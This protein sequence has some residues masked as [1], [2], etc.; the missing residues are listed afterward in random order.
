MLRYA[1][2]EQHPAL[3]VEMR[4][5]KSLVVIRRIAIDRGRRILVVAPNSALDSWEDELA[6]ERQTYVR[7]TGDRSQRLA[8]LRSPFRWYL[9]NREAWRTLPEIAGRDLCA[10]CGGQG[11]RRSTLG[12]DV[13]DKRYAPYDV[14]ITRSGKWG[15]PFRIGVDGDRATVIQ[16][17]R[18]Y[19]LTKPNLLE[20]LHE[21]ANKRL[22]CVCA[23]RPCHGDV[24]R[25]L[26]RRN[27]KSSWCRSCDGR[28]YGPVVRKS[29]WEHVVVDESFLRNPQA[30]ITQFYL[31]SFRDVQHRW[32]LTGLANPESRLD[33][34][35]QF[36]WLDGHFLGF[37]SYWA[38]RAKCFVPGSYGYGWTPTPDAAQAIDREVGR[39]AYVLTRKAA[40][41]ESTK[42]YERR[43]LELPS[44]LR[45]VYDH[46]EAEFVR[47]LSSGEEQETNFATTRWVW[48]RQLCGGICDGRIVWKDPYIE[49]VD[50][51][52]GELRN[53]QVVVWFAFVKEIETAQAF[54]T[55]SRPTK[56]C[57]F[58]HGKVKQDTRRSIQRSFRDGATRIL[59]IQEDLGKTG[60]N[61]GKADTAIYFSNSPSFDARSQ[62]E[63]RIL[64]IDKPGPLL[65]IDMIVKDTV[66]ED[67]RSVLTMKRW[68][69]SASIRRAVLE[70][71]QARCS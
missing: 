26:V 12:L 61:L 45:S 38:Y 36:A 16:M 18:A 24:L 47:I 22:G 31:S 5:G 23:P 4:L 34:W 56:S 10:T 40:G 53:E 49:L 57:R 33:Y 32:L 9:L 62:S 14:D 44:K 64:L 50:L 30:K 48:L 52:S 35:S 42:V 70:R 6:A 25:E 54:L 69:S 8:K 65:Y 39:R 55:K 20:D 11:R 15:N 51:L 67:I 2:N 17:Y 7:V 37:S 58:L 28:G 3:L 43:T 59:L 1:L 19:L 63:D 68:K 71:M 21:L 27:V 46:T 29:G 41:C 66:S 60:I 13:V